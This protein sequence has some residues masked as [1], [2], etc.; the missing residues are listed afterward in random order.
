MVSITIIGTTLLFNA[1]IILVKMIIGTNRGDLINYPYWKKIV[2]DTLNLILFGF[3]TYY[4]VKENLHYRQPQNLIMPAALL[5]AACFLIFARKRAMAL[6]QKLVRHIRS[7]TQRQSGEA[8]ATGEDTLA[9]TESYNRSKEYIYYSASYFCSLTLIVLSLLY[10]LLSLFAQGLL[11]QNALISLLFQRPGE[12]RHLCA[13]LNESLLSLA[14]IGGTVT[15]D[16]FQYDFHN[17]E[18]A[19]YGGYPADNVTRE[20]LRKNQLKLRVLNKYLD[21][22]EGPI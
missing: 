6:L 21:D 12:W 8:A 11:Q 3:I 13:N 5:A 1:I 15:I 9:E 16:K 19:S 2:S 22:K 18:N 10:I 7:V 14:I 4:A 20:L 17:R